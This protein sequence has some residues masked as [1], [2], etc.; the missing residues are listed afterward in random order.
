MQDLGFIPNIFVFVELYSL[1]IRQI[2]A[3]SPVIYRLTRSTLPDSNR[4]DGPSNGSRPADEVMP[5][6]LDPGS[7]G[8]NAADNADSMVLN[9]LLL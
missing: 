8:L 7:I 2:S 1:S 3:S 5:Q 9:S 6:V 4:P